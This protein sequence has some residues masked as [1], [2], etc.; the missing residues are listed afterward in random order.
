MSP[1]YAIFLEETIN[2]H[3][4]N[5]KIEQLGDLGSFQLIISSK[6]VIVTSKVNPSSINSAKINFR[7]GKNFRKLL[8]D[9]EFKKLKE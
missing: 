4:Q 5:G 6:C 2:E 7:A 8:K 9:L 1:I 3:L